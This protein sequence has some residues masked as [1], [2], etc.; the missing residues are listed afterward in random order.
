MLRDCG[1]SR[2]ADQYEDTGNLPVTFSA[3]IVQRRRTG[4]SPTGSG[5]SPLVVHDGNRYDPG[6]TP[7]SMRPEA[8]SCVPN[9]RCQGSKV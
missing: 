3:R 8:A 2:D 5:Q 9:D 1:I 6:K 7:F 4:Q